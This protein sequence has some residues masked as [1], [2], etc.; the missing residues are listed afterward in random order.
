MTHDAKLFSE[1][2]PLADLLA[3]APGLRRI[4][5]ALLGDEQLAEDVTQQVLHRALTDP[6]R[7][8]SR[9]VGWL[10]AVTRNRALM[11]V[12]S[13]RR[14]THRE[15]DAARPEP[16]PA[17][18]DLVERLDT[19]HKVVEAVLCLAEPWRSVVLLHHFERCKL[20]EI[21]HRLDAPVETIRTRLKRAH[22]LLRKR[23]ARD[24]G[25]EGRCRHALLAVAG[26][27]A[28]ALPASAIPLAGAACMSA[29]SKTLSVGVVLAVAAAI[30]LGPALLP[31]A[32][33]ARPTSA[34]KTAGAEAATTGAPPA[35]APR[36]A[37]LPSAPP[38]DPPPAAAPPTFAAAPATLRSSLEGLVI[39]AQDRP[40]GG[41]SVRLFDAGSDGAPAPIATASTDADGGF[42]FADRVFR[43]RYPRAT[44]YV[45]SPGH[46]IG[47]T[48]V[49]LPPSGPLL[50]R[51]RGTTTLRGRVS[52]ERVGPIEG[53]RVSIASILDDQ[54]Q[55]PGMLLVPDPQLDG[56]ATVTQ[57]DGSFELT[58]LPRGQSVNVLIEATGHATGYRPLALSGTERSGPLEIVLRTGALIRGRVRFAD[59]TPVIGAQVC[60]QACDDHQ[61]A[62]SSWG[63][64]LS[65]ERGEYALEGLA[66]GPWNVFVDLQDAAEREW[67][68]AARDHIELPAG[69]APTTVDF[70]L[71]R[72]ALLNI[73]VVDELSGGGIPQVW[74]GI[75][76]SARPRSGPA[77]QG[78][79]T[80]ADGRASARVPPGL[81][82]VYLGDVPGYQVVATGEEFDA[83]EGDSRELRFALA[84]VLSELRGSVLGPDG[85]PIAGARVYSTAIG[86]R[87]GAETSTAADGTFTLV[88][89]TGSGGLVRAEAFGLGMPRAIQ[90][91]AGAP[92]TLVLQPTPTFGIAGRV[93]WSNG[94]PVGGAQVDLYESAIHGD[95]NRPAA[96][97]RATR[98]DAEGR[99]SFA[100]AW[101]GVV[102]QAEACDLSHSDSERPRTGRSV[103]VEATAGAPC[104]LGDISLAAWR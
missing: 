26:G 17:T 73:A 10:R 94:L 20:A 9:L 72:G 97:A 7:D 24:F 16:L 85:A 33:P 43:A 89:P 27:S 64:T 91:Q 49:S 56:V 47:G 62:E 54:G 38:T 28:A 1:D 53:A 6:P 18:A 84:P 50:I 4:A 75:V 78:L 58:G 81:T 98:T 11:E 36:A 88:L 30:L 42:H 66:A 63:E 39:D 96:K 22:V 5:R 104:D 61:S 90:A 44:L 57:R 52:G 80:D 76:C 68:C 15:L 2:R 21:A 87:D 25:G 51:L 99:Y 8:P 65:D 101:P 14:R 31:E 12:R 93:L 74:I 102:Y 100:H 86:M 92:V 32:P 71:V 35:I 67:T 29:L 103:A 70:T 83:R 82:R 34:A 69:A 40:I 19:Q 77:V 41:A 45:I 59:G 55:G 48:T 13:A 95:A 37:A 3:H 23:L 79:V 60:A 46:A